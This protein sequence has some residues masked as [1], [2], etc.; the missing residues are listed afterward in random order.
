MKNNLLILTGPQGSGNH[1]WAKIFSSDLSVNGW[2]MKDYWQGHHTEPFNHWWHDVNLIRDTGHEY[3]F[4]SISCP[5]VNDKKN[6]IP[7]YH[8]FIKHA[9]RFYN[10]KVCVIG[11]DQNILNTQ[12][13]R[14]RE[15]VTIHHFFEGLKSLLIL[16]NL[17][18]I[19]TELLYLYKKDYLIYL[20]KLLDFP[21]NINSV[22]DIVDTNEKYIQSVDAQPLDDEVKKAI[23]DSSNTNW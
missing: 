22:I 23:A 1:L 11:R 7:N 4:T 9:K 19:S 2:R 14:V 3:N 17:H 15:G 13:I 12:Q 8:E 21:I 10:V 6:V 18:F 5:Y 20:S 16:D